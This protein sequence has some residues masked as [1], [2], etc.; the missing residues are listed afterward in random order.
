MLLP[1]GDDNP[2]ERTPWVTWGLV[3]LNAVLFLLW[4]F[5]DPRLAQHVPIYALYPDRA[6]WG[7][8]SFLKTVF[9]SMFMHAGVAHLAGNMLFLWIFGDN[10]EDKLGHVAYLAF[11]LLSGVAAALAQVLTTAHPGLPMVGASGAVSGV[12]GAYVVF[13]PR[14]PI[15]L[16][17]LLFVYVRI[18]EVAAFWWIGFWFL[19]QSLFASLGAGGGVAYAA[20]IGGFLVGAAVALPWKFLLAPARFGVGGDVKSV[21]LEFLRASRPRRLASAVELA[22]P[23]SGPGIEFLPDSPAERYR[24]LRLSPDLSG[25]KAVGR[26]VNAATG[27]DSGDVQDRLHRT[28]GV[29]ARGLDRAAA[30]GLR[31]RLHKEGIESLVAPDRVPPPP[32]LADRL[33]WTRDG[34]T[35]GVDGRLLAF[36]WSAPYLFLG[37]AIQGLPILDIHAPPGHVVR[38]TQRTRFEGPSGLSASL[39]QFAAAVIANRH[40]AILN[41]GVRVLAHHGV[42]GWLN[43]ASDDDYADYAAW[44]R[45]LVTSRRTQFRA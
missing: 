38:V 16:F 42:W 9:T 7:D 21:P 23:A 40:G 2:R 27:E 4:C 1:I 17:F 45:H 24:L 6:D 41:E 14:Q 19:Q 11:Y 34:F 10:V 12:L 26:I 39:G 25:L 33:T 15:R 30:D 36:R 43:F 37:A 13:F 32:V 35:I 22:A 8:P 44:S 31:W 29:I 5:P 20:H 18:L 28:R 3:G